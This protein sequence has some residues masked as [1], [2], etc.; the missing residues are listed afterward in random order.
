MP[1]AVDLLARRKALK[2]LPL[3]HL[4]LSGPVRRR[5]A[6]L[7]I[8]A[9]CSACGVKREYVVNNLLSGRTC[10]C[11]CQRSLKYRS[12]LAKV[13]G[14]R[15]DALRQRLP[16]RARVPNREAFVHYML[17][18]AANTKPTIRTAKQLRRFRIQRMND[19]RGFEKGNLCLVETRR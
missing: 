19:R 3:G 13:F 1:A 11:R 8:H 6:H 18:L 9:V 17:A 14:Q 5:G 7:Y 10:D 4:T 2:K 15:Y 16:N 12:P